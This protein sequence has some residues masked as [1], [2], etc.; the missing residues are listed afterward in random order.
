[1]KRLNKLSNNSAIKLEYK[2][3]YIASNEIG[4]QLSSC[5]Q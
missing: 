1:M 5:S 2:I 3:N 4:Q